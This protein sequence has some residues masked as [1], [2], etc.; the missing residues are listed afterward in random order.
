MN[1]GMFSEVDEIKLGKT[2]S[3]I[4]LN[5]DRFSELNGYEPG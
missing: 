4:G 5:E 2:Q 1:L 3:L